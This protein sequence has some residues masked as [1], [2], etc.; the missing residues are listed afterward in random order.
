MIIFLDFD[1]VTHPEA[2]DDLF[3]C[4]SPLWKILRAC[5][6]VEVVFST[7][8][9]DSY[10]LD[11]LIGFVTSNGG[12][13]LSDR[14]VGV[15]AKLTRE[16]LADDYRSRELECLTWIDTNAPGRSWL[17]LD[18]IE[19]WFSYDCDSLYVVNYINGLTDE[20]AQK[21]IGRLKGE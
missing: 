13:E 6:S 7:S 18:D 19:Y 17:A 16:P 9:R 14:F 3:C 8:W 21:I 2:G 1:G 20:D 5:P 4:L 12:E 11:E 10:P 15:T